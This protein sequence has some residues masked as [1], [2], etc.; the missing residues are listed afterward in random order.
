MLV[1]DNWT[2]AVSCQMGDWY[3]IV[4]NTAYRETAEHYNVVV[5]LIRVGRTKDKPSVE[6]SLGKMSTWITVAVRD[7]QVSSLAKL[8]VDIREMLD[9]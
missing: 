3:T 4:L 1:F 9:A 8:N 6:G 7:E 5:F 2:T